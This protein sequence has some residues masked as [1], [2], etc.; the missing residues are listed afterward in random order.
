MI[1]YA[2]KITDLNGG[3]HAP[4]LHM[5]FLLSGKRFQEKSADIFAVD[6]YIIYIE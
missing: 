2:L 6:S 5:R 3:D 4:M 1:E